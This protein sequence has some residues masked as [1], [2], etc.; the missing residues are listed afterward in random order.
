MI[1]MMIPI[2]V[3]VQ[4]RKSQSFTI[5]VPTEDGSVPVERFLRLM[6]I[7]EPLEMETKAMVTDNPI[8]EVLMGQIYRQ[9]MEDDRDSG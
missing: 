1:W 5:P 9:E 7:R 4:G 2:T 3:Y 6:D 8:V